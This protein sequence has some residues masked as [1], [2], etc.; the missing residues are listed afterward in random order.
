MT[1]NKALETALE[2]VKAQK[3]NFG[4]LERFDVDENWEVTKALEEIQQYRAL[5]TVEEFRQMKEKATAK[6]VI[7]HRLTGVTF[8]NCPICDRA[9]SNSIMKVELSNCF[10]CGQK[11][12]WSEGRE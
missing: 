4:F 3:I 6:K 5:G 2:K 1:E 7:E 10:W 12:D 9:A 11:L 8:Y